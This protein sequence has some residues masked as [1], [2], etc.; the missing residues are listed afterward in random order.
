[1]PCLPIICCNVLNKT[2]I[3]SQDAFTAPMQC[4]LSLSVFYLRWLLW[5]RLEAHSQALLFTASARIPE[6][7]RNGQGLKLQWLMVHG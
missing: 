5:G 7:D 3:T 4:P 6:I 2:R 1:M